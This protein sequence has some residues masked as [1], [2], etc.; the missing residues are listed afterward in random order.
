[1][2]WFVNMMYTESNY[3]AGLLVGA[4]MLDGFNNDGI[5]QLVQS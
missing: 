3:R 2:L 4:S 1:M 5:C